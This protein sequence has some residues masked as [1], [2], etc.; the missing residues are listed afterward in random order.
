MSH[1]IDYILKM[2]PYMFFSLPFL[3]VFRIVSNIRMKKH[4]IKNTVFHEL[5]VCIFS[6]FSVGLASITAIPK[7][8]F[9]N[10]SFGV[11]NGF[12]GINLIPFTVFVQTYSEV[13]R[14]GN[15]SYFLINFLGNII[16]FMPFGFFIPLL[17]QK[18]SFG[19][20]VF[21]TFCITLFIESA[22]LLQ[23]RGSDVDDLWL[24]VLGGI[25]GYVC[26]KF[27]SLKFPEFCDK[28][29]IKN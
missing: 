22:Q 5:G 18:I 16:I 20:T 26:Y 6:L 4:S 10:V 2:L 7:F 17:W 11:V 9:G 23:P 13:F 8:Q 3:A 19:K 12:G 25:L 21:I 27:L 24:N 15:I 29:K 28:F 1:I 14:Y